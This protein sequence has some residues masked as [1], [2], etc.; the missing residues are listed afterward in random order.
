MTR[1]K[2]STGQG[3]WG[4]LR[5]VL[6]LLVAGASTSNAFAET[7]PPQTLDDLFSSVAARAPEF[8]GMFLTEKVLGQRLNRTQLPAV[9][10][11][12]ILQVYL[13]HVSLGRIAAV[14][15]AIVDVF[16]AEVIPAGGIVPLHGNFGFSKLREW[17]TRVLGE[18]FSIPGVTMTDIDETNNK[19]LIGVEKKQIEADVIKLLFK[20]SIPPRA[21]SIEVINVQTQATTTSNVQSKDQLASLTLDSRVRPTQGGYQIHPV[22]QDRTHCTLGFNATRAGGHTGFTTSSWCTDLHWQM[23][24]TSFYQPGFSLSDVVGSETLDP[25]GFATGGFPC[26]KQMRCRYSEAAFV[27]YDPIYS[28]RGGAIAKTT[29]LTTTSIAN[30]NVD[31]TQQFGIATAPSLPYLVGLTL[32]KVGRRTGWTNGQI[33]STCADFSGPSGLILCQYTVGNSNIPDPNWQIGD[34]S[35]YGAPVFRLRD[36]SYGGW[37]YVELYGM[38]WGMV[39]SP[40]Y[41]VFA[42][43]PIGGVPFQQTGI[44]SSTDLGPLDYLHCAL[45]PGPPRC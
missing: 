45:P 9:N 30:T 33:V 36:F 43:S 4:A 19:I 17:Y 31:P 27:D 37:E 11:R 12:P 44:Q 16:G 24:G 23:D 8:G 42:F 15:K 6:A 38:F 14:R 41:Q 39:G 29:G 13:T 26:P 10:E 28:V 40:P 35:D 21:A 25:P 1:F 18:V 3:S 2:K 22:L 34:V 32:N 20:L 5:F 7:P